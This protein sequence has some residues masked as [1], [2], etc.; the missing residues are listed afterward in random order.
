MKDTVIFNKDNGEVFYSLLMVGN[1]AINFY[2]VKYMPDERKNW[3]NFYY[4]K[5][6]DFLLKEYE[7]NKIKFLNLV[8]ENEKKWLDSLDDLYGG[9]KPNHYWNDC[10]VEMETFFRIYHTLNDYELDSVY[11][12]EMF[13][14]IEGVWSKEWG[15]MTGFLPKM[16]HYSVP[17]L[18]HYPVDYL[19]EQVDI[20]KGL[21]L[22]KKYAPTYYSIL[23]G[24]YD[25]TIKKP[26]KDFMKNILNVMKTLIDEKKKS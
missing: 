17:K 24:R 25:P 22:V 14:S 15:D 13:S 19:E 12:A 4:D 2:T 20:A 21:D 23:K 10:L 5:A 26:N 18:R 9:P 1:T 16:K 8:K 3:K 7:K 6:C 11:V